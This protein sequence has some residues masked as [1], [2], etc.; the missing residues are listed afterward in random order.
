MISI[1]IIV[2]GVIFTLISVY[3]GVLSPIEEGDTFRVRIRNS[4]NGELLLHELTVILLTIGYIL[5]IDE[6][7]GEFWQEV[8]PL[9]QRLI[10][11]FFA[12]FFV[13]AIN[14]GRHGRFGFATSSMIRRYCMTLELIVDSESVPEKGIEEAIATIRK[15]PESYPEDMVEHFL[16]FLSKR[17]DQVGIV[18]KVQL[19]NLLAEQN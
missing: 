9:Y 3:T 6:Y 10:P 12:T 16:Y 8:F 19:D 2:S 14:I 5:Y 1:L 11:F 15:S 18:A 7:G 13:F 4:P 17:E